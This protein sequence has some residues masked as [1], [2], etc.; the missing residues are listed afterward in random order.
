[1]PVTSATVTCA[2]IVNTAGPDR[3]A[4]WTTGRTSAAEVEAS[5]T[6]RTT[7]AAGGHSE[8]CYGALSHVVRR[9]TAAKEEV[10]TACYRHG[11]LTVRVPLD[12]TE[13]PVGRNV[14]IESRSSAATSSR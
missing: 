10:V 7:Q 2:I 6:A 1:V 9:P 14:T 3:P 5:S 4:S 12:R 8:F 11:V 13:H